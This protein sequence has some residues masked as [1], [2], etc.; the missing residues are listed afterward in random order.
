MKI[1]NLSLAEYNLK[2]LKL[3]I[4]EAYSICFSEFRLVGIDLSLSIPKLTYE[5]ENDNTDLS[6]LHAIGLA[7]MGGSNSEF[8]GVSKNYDTKKTDGAE[9]V[10]N[11]RVYTV[12]EIQAGNVMETEAIGVEKL[13]LPVYQFLGTGDWKTALS[14]FVD[15][16]T[17]ITNFKTNNPST[18]DLIDSIGSYIQNYINNHY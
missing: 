8:W 7:H 12:L 4:A 13:L 11:K 9:F 1:G 18:V 17:E 6:I 5:F 15:K 3:E 14:I 16:T 2:N 10:E